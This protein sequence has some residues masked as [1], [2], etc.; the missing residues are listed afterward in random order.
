MRRRE[1]LGVLGTTAAWPIGAR[2]QQAGKLRTIGFIGSS[3]AAQSQHAAFVERLRE[4]GWIE[5]RSVAIEYRWVEGHSE[6]YPEIVAEFVRRKV[7]VIVASAAG[8][9]AAK[10]VTA[11]IPI[12]FYIATD[13]IGVGLVKSLARPGGNVT[14][15]SNQSTDL[16]GN[17]IQLL[18]EVVPGIRRLAILAN[19]GFPGRTLDLPLRRLPEPRALSAAAIPAPRC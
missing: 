5:G 15:L 18:S 7:D 11:L 2:A 14:G 12:V 16:P 13:P 6:R 3:T 10:E 17:R 8:A 1:F 9:A 4:L 19:V